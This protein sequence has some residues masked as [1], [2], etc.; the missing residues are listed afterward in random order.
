MPDPVS[1]VDA[2]VS[3]SPEAS[4]YVAP[5]PF[6]NRFTII[7]ENGEDTA[8]FEKCDHYINWSLSSPGVLM[9]FNSEGEAWY[10]K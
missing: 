8:I 9:V 7:R 1:I 3:T 4:V 10:K 6:C 5:C 2:T